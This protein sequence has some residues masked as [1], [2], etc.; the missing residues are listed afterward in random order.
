MGALLSATDVDAYGVLGVRPDATQAD[1]KAAHRALVRR[2]HPD[3]ATAEQRDAATRRVQE[4]NVAY[5]LVRDAERRA[6][7]DRAAGARGGGMDRL[8]TAA[9]VWAGRWWVR[10]RI[11]LRRSAAVAQSGLRTG[12]RIA[13]RA[14]AETVGRVLWL[15]LC[16]VGLALGWFA[17]WSAQR[18]V[19]T[20]GFITPL[21]GTLGGLALGNQRGWLLRLRLRGIL[22]PPDA[23]RFAVVVWLVAMGAALWL[24]VRLASG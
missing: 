7:Y 24:D 17:A 10:N 1:I 23:A 21:T 6:S 12:G 9:G 15:L 22:V 4:I 19:G 14:A 5:G 8:V 2:H 11:P 16:A 3:L 13:R 18:V 20:T